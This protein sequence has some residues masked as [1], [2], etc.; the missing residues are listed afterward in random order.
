MSNASEHRGR[1]ALAVAIFAILCTG[2]LHA[3]APGNG[4]IVPCDFDIA[5]DI[6]RFMSGGT[7]HLAGLPGGPTTTGTFLLING[8]NPSD[9]VDHDGYAAPGTCNYNNIYIPQ[10]FLQNLVNVDNPALAIPAQNIVIANL[11]RALPSGTSGFVSAY[12]TIP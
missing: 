5:D 2:P 1:Y 12:V 7:L 11:P 9:D 8:D 4:I 3:Q 10:S 6:G